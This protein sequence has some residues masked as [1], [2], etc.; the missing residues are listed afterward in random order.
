MAGPSG[1][2]DIMIEARA[3]VHSDGAC[4]A[5]TNQRC[6]QVITLRYNQFSS[7][8]IKLCWNCLEEL[9]EVIKS[10]PKAARQ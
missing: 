5:C 9:P 7:Q 10:S 1:R 3:A 8:S 4:S 6:A 2:K